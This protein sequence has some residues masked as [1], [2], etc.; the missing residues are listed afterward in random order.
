MGFLKPYF[1]I[2]NPPKIG[3]LYEPALH[4]NSFASDLENDFLLPFYSETNLYPWNK[5]AELYYNQYIEKQIKEKIQKS[6]LAWLNQEIKKKNQNLQKLE[7][8][9]LETQRKEQYKIYG[10]LLKTIPCPKALGKDKI[11]ATNYFSPDL[12]LLSIP[13][14]K[15]LSV[16]QNMEKYFKLYRKLH[17]AS[18]LIPP[19]IARIQNQLLPL[20]ESKKK[21]EQAEV[22]QT[23]SVVA[24]IPEGIKN[25]YNPLPGTG[26]FFKP[27]VAKRLPYYLF[28]SKDK[29]PILVGKSAKDNDELTFK[30]AS[31][32]DFWFHARNYP[33][34]HV[35]VKCGKQKN[36]SET[37]ML[38]AAHLAAHY[39]DAKE[40]KKVEIVYTQRKHLSKPKGAK[41]G[42][43]L[44]QKEKIFT[45]IV[46][47]K[48]LE[49]ILE[50]KA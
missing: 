16:L 19:Q 21:I 23:E 12:E 37:A 22:L 42:L 30:F 45:L 8:H 41:P 20:L 28:E 39:S 11:E 46:E 15:N 36:L 50:S 3:N 49:R 17:K 13:L 27:P 2:A 44:I 14:L 48:R 4:L 9:L 33:G 26:I 5:A 32:N 31:G 10:E 6:W 18:E 47:Q 35:V 43:V 1:K 38:D 29:T 34:S 40:H 25:Q 7:K 24:E